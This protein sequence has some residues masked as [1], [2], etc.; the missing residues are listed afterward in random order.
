[1]QHVRLH[2]IVLAVCAAVAIGAGTKI[3]AVHKKQMTKK[4]VPVVLLVCRHNQEEWQQYTNARARL[5]PHSCDELYV[6]AGEVMQM[7]SKQLQKKYGW[8]SVPSHI[9]ID[10]CPACEERKGEWLAEHPPKKYKKGE[11]PPP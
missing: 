10:V 7:K 11:V 1:M 9:W 8:K 2:C 6:D 5:F 4:K 3:C